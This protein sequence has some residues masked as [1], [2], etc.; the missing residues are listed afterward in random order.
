MVIADD[1]GVGIDRVLDGAAKAVTGETHFAVDNWDCFSVV[2][3]NIIG[4][5]LD[6]NK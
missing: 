5:N 3:Y 1:D 2:N 6:C 4:L